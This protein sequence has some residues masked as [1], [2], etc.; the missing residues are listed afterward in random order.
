MATPPSSSWLDHSVVPQRVW[1]AFSCLWPAPSLTYVELLIGGWLGRWGCP[2][3]CSDG[4]R[5]PPQSPR[6]KP[7]ITSSCRWPSQPPDVK[8]S[9]QQR[10]LPA[11]GLWFMLHPLLICVSSCSFV[12]TYKNLP[13]YYIGDF[14]IYFSICV[15]LAWLVQ[16]WPRAPDQTELTENKFASSW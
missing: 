8:P 5:P 6:T 9:W 13:L 2:P 12:F 14:V 10:L 7:V 11:V 15:L 4:W 3:S 16:S 1:S